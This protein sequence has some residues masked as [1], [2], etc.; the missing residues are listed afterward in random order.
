[1]AGAGPRSRIIPDTPK[2]GFHYSTPIPLALTQDPALWYPAQ[3]LAA[4]R[5]KAG[6]PLENK[7]ANVWQELQGEYKLLRGDEG[8][9]RAARPS[10]KLVAMILR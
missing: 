6:G 9:E 10:E 3:T 5:K 1:M 8:S 2:F 7:Q 4:S